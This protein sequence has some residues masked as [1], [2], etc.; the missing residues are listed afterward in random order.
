MIPSEW[1]GVVWEGVGLVLVS[2]YIFDVQVVLWL[3]P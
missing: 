1:V 3:V 2:R